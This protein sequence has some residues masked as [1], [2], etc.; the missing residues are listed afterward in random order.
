MD[1]L[2]EHGPEGR[3]EEMSS[4]VISLGVETDIARDS[5]GDGAERECALYPADNRHAFVCFTD[6]LDVHAP[7][8][9][10]DLTLVGD[11]ASGL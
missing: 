10:D 9:A 11:L 3:V 7:A 1:V 2:A 8:V 6:I 4:R 5:R